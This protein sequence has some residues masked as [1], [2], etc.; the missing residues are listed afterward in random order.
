VGAGTV[1]A[2][3]WVSYAL[4]AVMEVLLLTGLALSCTALI[5]GLRGN[6][7]PNVN[8][9]VRDRR[10]HAGLAL[11]AVALALSWGLWWGAAAGVVAAVTLRSATTARVG[12]LALVLAR[13]GGDAVTR[14]DN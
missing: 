10:L 9:V 12:R 1:S 3:L 5:A 11:V 13:G 6:D 7:R 4:W 2:P 14:P 8:A